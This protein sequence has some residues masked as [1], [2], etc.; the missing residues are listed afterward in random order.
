[1]K[2]N[3]H[4]SARASVKGQRGRAKKVKSLNA[5]PKL[6]LEVQQQ[7]TSQTAIRLNRGIQLTHVD[8]KTGFILSEMKSLCELVSKHVQQVSAVDESK[9]K[10]LTSGDNCLAMLTQEHG[11][12]QEAENHAAKLHAK[13]SEQAK[14]R[15]SIS[16]APEEQLRS[17]GEDPNSLREIKRTAEDERKLKKLAG[18]APVMSTIDIPG[19][20]PVQSVLGGGNQV[21]L[22]QIVR[23]AKIALSSNSKELLLAVTD[24]INDKYFSAT[25][26][27]EPVPKTYRHRSEHPLKAGDRIHAKVEAH[28]QREISFHQL[29]LEF[30]LVEATEQETGRVAE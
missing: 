6:K 16:R 1:M 5:P 27:N 3:A 21:E 30:R 7:Q 11:S 9:V 22:D 17:A 8:N 23:K 18:G 12:H 2:T 4:N 15:E 24:I 26:D 25:T 10:V 29:V 20:P 14:A 28:R 13:V 19:H